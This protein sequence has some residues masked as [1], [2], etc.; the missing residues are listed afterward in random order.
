MGD[1][2]SKIGGSHNYYKTTQE[3]KDAMKETGL[4]SFGTE[5]KRKEVIFGE[6]GL[7]LAK[8]GLR[9]VQLKKIL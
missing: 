1:E 6:G 4:T 3:L 8:A 7:F 5:G 2:I 9:L